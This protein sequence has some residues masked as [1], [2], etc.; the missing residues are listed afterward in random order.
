[1]ESLAQT[2]IASSPAFFR[3]LFLLFPSFHLLSFFSSSFAFFILLLSSS[4]TPKLEIQTTFLRLFSLE[5]LFFFSTGEFERSASSNL[6]IPLS[7][8]SLCA[9]LSPRH[10]AWEEFQPC[11]G[12]NRVSA[13]FKAFSSKLCISLCRIRLESFSSTGDFSFQLIS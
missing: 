10:F 7:P 5:P 4:N 3:R 1:M 8:S 9:F 6:I 2:A 13:T 11:L 12:F